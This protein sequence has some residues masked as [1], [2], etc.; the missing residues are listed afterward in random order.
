[1]KKHPNVFKFLNDTMR[2]DIEVIRIALKKDERNYTHIPKDKKE[3]VEIFY[4]L[5]K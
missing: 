2:S 5:L 1:M 4:E 3:Q